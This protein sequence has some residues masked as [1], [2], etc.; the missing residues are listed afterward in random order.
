MTWW[1]VLNVLS[2]RDRER[3]VV[4]Y[5]TVQ[6]V[7][8]TTKNVS[9]NPAPGEVYS[10]Q[11]YVIKFVSDLR[12]VGGFLRMLRFHPSIKTGHAPRYYRCIVE[13]GVNHHNTN[14]STYQTFIFDYT[15]VKCIEMCILKLRETKK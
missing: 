2:T 1:I 13:S 12:H 4:G 10:L 14:L 5:T 11:N 7:P 3:M 15:V 6:S 9:S 8:I